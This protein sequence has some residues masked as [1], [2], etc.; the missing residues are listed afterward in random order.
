MSARR[1][2]SGTSCRGESGATVLEAVVVIPVAMLVL[3][4]AVQACLWAHANAI[5]QAAAADGLQH[6]TDLGGSPSA[7]AERAHQVLDATGSSVVADPSVE[8]QVVDGSQ[9]ELT[10]TGTA[11]SII[12]WLHLHVAAVRRAPIQEF[13]S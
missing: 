4:V 7:G 5:V 2:R 8:S 12:P 11:E 6:A 13:R 1:R 10:V 3:L 9:V